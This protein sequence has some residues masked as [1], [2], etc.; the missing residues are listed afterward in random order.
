MSEA[1]LDTYTPP[2]ILAEKNNLNEGIPKPP[3]PVLR[4]DRHFDNKLIKPFDSIFYSPDAE[5]LNND[6]HQAELTET[7][8]NLETIDC[9][10]APSFMV[11]QPE[12][13][14]QNLDEIK[15][16]TEK[17]N[18]LRSMG[19]VITRNGVGQSL[20]GV[21]FSREQAEAII[22]YANGNEGYVSFG[23]PS[24]QDQ[25]RI[26]FDKTKKEE[27]EVILM[28]SSIVAAA[29]GKRAGETTVT[30]LDPNGVQG[31]KNASIK[32]LTLDDIKFPEKPPEISEILKKQCD[33]EK[34]KEQRN[35]SL[36]V[37]SLDLNSSSSTYKEVIGYNQGDNERV[38]R[39]LKESYGP[40][41]QIT[42]DYASMYPGR[43][44][45]YD[46]TGDS[47]VFV[48][49][50]NQ[51]A[52]EASLAVKAH[53]SVSLKYAI[54]EDMQDVTTFTYGD[55]VIGMSK[56]IDATLISAAEKEHKA[57]M[58]PSHVPVVKNANALAA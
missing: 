14:F 46:T 57:S 40:I 20:S 31:E 39:G 21:A 41:N 3:L 24:P 42:K 7:I 18:K 56:Q 44:Q 2:I 10:D 30:Q 33:V 23:I 5:T 58:T 13:T 9:G 16:D 12:K 32:R 1:I 29:R 11:I 43:V 48:T 28:T 45:L 17:M 15:A 19:I 52:H 54:I 8:K 51:I 35:P 26:T 37:V 53:Y 25:T 4:R 38:K 55:R 49:G 34:I 6:P 36:H 27:P 47:A 22:E 50:N